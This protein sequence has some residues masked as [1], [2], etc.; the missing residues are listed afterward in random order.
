MEPVAV[1]PADAFKALGIGTTK[2]YELINAG[3]LKRI[4]IGRASRITVASIRALVA[5]AA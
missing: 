5:E 1:T 2:G 3:K 4:K